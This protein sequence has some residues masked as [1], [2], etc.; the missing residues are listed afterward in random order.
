MLCTVSIILDA[1]VLALINKKKSYSSL[2]RMI[3][4]YICDKLEE[5]LPHDSRAKNFKMFI[6]IS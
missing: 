5:L 3:A 2:D 6:L 1:D 4:L